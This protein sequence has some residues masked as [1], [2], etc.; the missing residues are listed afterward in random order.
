MAPPRSPNYPSLSLSEALTA[1]GPALKAEN[2]NKMGKL[3]LAKHLGYNSLNGRALSKIGAV[4]AYGLIEGGNDE[5]RVSEDAVVCLKAPQDSSERKAA[6]ERC[7]TRPPLF[8][9]IRSDFPDTLPSLDNLGFWLAKQGYTDK[10]AG[11]AAETYL[12]TM[13]LVGG[14]SE[15]YTPPSIAK[16]EEYAPGP[17]ANVG[18]MVTVERGGVLVSPAP[19]RVL[20]VQEREGVTWV[21]TDGA[22]SWTEMDTVTV[23]SKGAPAPPTPPPP[24]MLRNQQTDEAEPLVAGETEWMR[25]RLGADTK[26]RLLVTGEMGPREIGKLIKLLE[27]QRAVLD[28]DDDD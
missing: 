16:E 15:A 19:V 18:D 21:W 10:A 7:A 17:Q 24:L 11:K 25:N 6:L 13:R 4:R 2:R 28:D 5:L 23:A 27:A 20:D 1:V 26:V 12:A 14:D 3:T 8:K 22:S 9:A